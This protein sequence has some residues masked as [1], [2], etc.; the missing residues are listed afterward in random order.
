MQE[1]DHFDLIEQH[2]P[3]SGRRILDVGCGDGW[4]VE[5][6]TDRGALAL[7]IDVQ[8]GQF[9]A[10]SGGIYIVA[11]GGK[12]PLAD[13]SVHA[14][15]YVASMHHMP[16]ADMAD[17]LAE[18]RRVLLPGGQA[19]IIEPMAEGDYFEL[20]EPVAQEGEARAAAYDV[21]RASR[22]IGLHPVLDDYYERI[23]AFDGLDDLKQ[24]LVAVDPAREARWATGEEAVRSTF[25]ACV[26]L[27]NNKRCFR[28]PYRVNLLQRL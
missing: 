8:A 11:S 15:V 12:L 23:V 24:R 26:L 7:G 3:L 14:V 5:R 28:Q 6:L 1:R 10:G 13:H 19:L 27:R 21:I 16:I 18:T 25:D 2:L 4:L 20:I 22:D 9:A 17:A